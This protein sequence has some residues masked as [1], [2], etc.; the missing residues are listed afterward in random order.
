MDVSARR[1]RPVL[2]AVHQCLHAAPMDDPTCHGTPPPKSNEGL[3]RVLCG[4]Y[5][6]V[7]G[8]KDVMAHLLPYSASILRIDAKDPTIKCI[9]DAALRCVLCCRSVGLRF[10]SGRC[11]GFPQITRACFALLGQRWAC[12]AYDVAPW[13]LSIHS[14]C[15]LRRSVYM[16]GGSPVYE[17]TS[18]LPQARKITSW[19]CACLG[20]S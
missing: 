5:S 16:S 18:R 13:S 4:V 2:C 3:S 17:T 19:T 20:V 6:N 8:R 12:M 14:A 15:E 7:S 11:P 9:L 1:T 10:G